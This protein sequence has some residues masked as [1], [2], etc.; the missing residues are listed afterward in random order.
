MTSRW[1]FQLVRSPEQRFEMWRSHWTLNFH[2]NVLKCK[3]EFF[4]F[5]ENV[6]KDRLSPRCWTEPGKERTMYA[7]MFIKQTVSKPVKITQF[8]KISSSYK[9]LTLRLPGFWSSILESMLIAVLSSP[10]DLYTSK[11]SE[12][13]K[14]SI[15]FNPNWNKSVHHFFR[16]SF[17]VWLL[18]F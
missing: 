6:F 16:F 1:R 13:R 10:D 18:Q 17:Y 3:V 12:N 9:I 11:T 8:T 4:N 5:K 7:A 15:R 2:L 14:P